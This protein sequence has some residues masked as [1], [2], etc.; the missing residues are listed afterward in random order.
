MFPFAV[1]LA[2][3][4]IEAVVQGLREYYG[5]PVIRSVGTH[6]RDDEAKLGENSQIPAK[7]TFSGHNI[8]TE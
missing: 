4:V 5:S 1:D 6:T 8:I 7:F 3:A 2:T